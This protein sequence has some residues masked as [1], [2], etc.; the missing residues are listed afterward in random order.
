MKTNRFVLPVILA[1][2]GFAQANL[3]AGQPSP[4]AAARADQLKAGVKS[5]RLQLDY[6]GEQDKPYYNVILSVPGIAYDRK[7]AFYPQVQITEEQ[8]KK[9][10]DY[11]AT[12]GVLD[13]ADDLKPGAVK[14][15]PAPT[16][17]GY[18]IRFTTDKIVFLGDLGWGRPMLKRLDE[19][20]KVLDGDAATQM[21]FLLTRLS[22][23]RREWEK[24]APTTKI[25]EVSSFDIKTKKPADQI[26]VKIVDDFATL[27]VFSPSG[28][29]GATIMVA[30]GNWPTTIIF[31]LHLSGLESF[32]ISNG[33]VKLTGSVLSHSG[34][35]KRLYLSEDGKDGKDG[36][37]EPGTEIKV[38]DAAGKPVKGLP[39]KGGYFEIMLPKALLESQP[40]SLEL[41]WIDFYRG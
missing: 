27:D 15:Y 1:A 37:R 17:P 21:D 33:K 18:T 10:I 31:R 28:I 26:K 11:W 25:A 9:V 5:F 24:E 38:L 4:K 20:R 6:N 29:G 2:F 36:E 14:K 40:K 23:H 7:N 22:G 41:G 32:A 30:K 8:A 13:R 12:A 16:M 19:F 35:T 34:N 3:Y 39:E